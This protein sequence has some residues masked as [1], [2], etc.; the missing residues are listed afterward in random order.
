MNVSFENGLIA[1]HGANRNF[2]PTAEEIYSTVFEGKTSIREVELDAREMLNLGLTFSDIPATP[3]IVLSADVTSSDEPRIHCK[4]AGKANTNLAIASTDY[5]VIE[6]TWYPLPQKTL[7]EYRILLNDLGISD[8]SAIELGQYLKIQKHATDFVIEDFAAEQM[9]AGQL[10]AKIQVQPLCGLAAKPYPYQQSGLQWL[11]FMTRH[12]VGSILADE[13]GL[14]K[15]LQVIAVL[16]AE[17]QANRRPNLVLGPATL[18]ENWR[19][20]LHRFAPT[21]KVLIHAGSRRTGSADVLSAADVTLTSYET[22]GVDISLFRAVKWNVVALDEAQNIK[23]PE[24]RRTKR[25]KELSKRVG[26]AITGT[27]VENRLKD[28]WSLCDFALPGHLGTLSEFEK[29]FPDSEPSATE[30][31]PFVSALMLRRRVRDVA[32]DL[33]SRIDIPVALVMDSRSAA[34]YEEIRTEAAANAP[35]APGLA[36]LVHLRM[37]CAHPWTVGKL[38]DVSSAIECS[39]KMERC[40]EILTEIFESESKAI[41]FTSFN[42]TADLLEGEIRQTFAVPVWKINGSVDVSDR[43]TIVDQF[44]AISGGAVLVLNPKAAGVG[45]NITAANHVIHYNLEWNPAVEDQA[46]ARAHRRGQT[47][48][49]TVHRLFYADTVEEII[50]DRMSRKRALA[51]HAVIGTAGDANDL[52]DIL[53]A[54]KRSPQSSYENHC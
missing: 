1:I 24:A 27:P 51:E 3:V 42:D 48:P 15:T 2:F 11:R 29:R 26:I 18:L 43:Q 10:S 32:T 13:M 14:G 39:P 19:R 4:L 16:L 46:S 33:P 44:S 9:A 54:L 17:S 7:D 34:A 28:L 37:F 20:E 45:L 31:E 35:K 53:N 41:V 5:V 12:G 50:N 25:T 38:Q 30:L 21:L 40:F 47:K 52:A 22:M 8:A 36:T 6:R 23:N 49:V